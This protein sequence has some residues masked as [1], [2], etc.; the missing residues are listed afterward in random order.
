MTIT[1][2]AL[3]APTID[4][5]VALLNGERKV[6]EQ[7]L[8]RITELEL[9]LAGAEH[10][11]VAKSLDEIDHAEND[12][13]MYELSRAIV[14][15]TL[16]PPNVPPTATSLLDICADHPQLIRALDD[17][18]RLVAAI[19]HGRERCRRISQERVETVGTAERRLQH[20]GFGPY[21]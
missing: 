9:L 8:F 17:L 11:F 19:E 7:L 18:K 21:G 5:L 15:E 12:L 3:A 20:Q 13:A 16:L 6:L 10:R 2:N 1:H 4:K 14:V